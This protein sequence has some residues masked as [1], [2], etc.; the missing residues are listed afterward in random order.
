MAPSIDTEAC[1]SLFPSHNQAI[2]S[3]VAASSNCGAAFA[4]HARGTV[5]PKR[6]T[7]RSKQGNTPLPEGLFEGWCYNACH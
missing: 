5:D 6:A 4:R 1:T 2:N 7:L 3:L